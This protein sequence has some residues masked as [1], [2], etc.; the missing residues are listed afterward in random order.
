MK[1]DI[2][3]SLVSPDFAVAAAAHF[4]TAY[5]VW[6]SESMVLHENLAALTCGRHLAGRAKHCPN[7]PKR[8]DRHGSR[9]SWFTAEM[10]S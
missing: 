5:L 2:N 7:S 1:N 4:V 6:A 3:K 9:P 8:A 10:Q